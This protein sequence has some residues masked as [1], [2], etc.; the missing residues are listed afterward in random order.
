M[1]TCKKCGKTGKRW[2][3]DGLCKSC[4]RKTWICKECG[5]EYLSIN[6]RDQC[7]KCEQAKENIV[8]DICNKQFPTKKSLANHRRYHNESYTKM[9]GSKHKGKIVSEETRKK[10]SIARTGKKLSEEHKKSI[11]RAVKERW[12]SPG[13]KEQYH[14]RNA[15]K[16]HLSEE[17]KSLLSSIRTKAWQTDEYRQH[18]QEALDKLSVRSVFQLDSVKEKIK[19]TSEEKY[20]GMGFGSD[21]VRAKI[22]ATKRISKWHSIDYSEDAI[23]LL[24]DKD[25]FDNAV[26]NDKIDVNEIAERYNINPNHLI[27][28]IWRFGK[29]DNIEWDRR[30]SQAE[31]LWLRRFEKAGFDFIEQASIYDKKILKCDFLNEKRKF[32][33]EINPTYTHSTFGR[34]NYG[35]VEYDYHYNRSREAEKNGYEVFHVWDWEDRNLV[36]SFIKSKLH[37]D[38]HKVS[39]R[40]CDIVELSSKQANDFLAKNH[41]QGGIAKGQSA[42][43]G[44]VY[45]DVLLQVSTYGYS[46][47][48]KSYEWECLRSCSLLDWHIY[49]GLSRLQNYFI[50]QKKPKSLIAYTDYSRSNGAMNENINRRF[51]NYTGPSLVWYDYDRMLR[52]TLIR[53]KGAC[54]ILGIDRIDREKTGLSNN[55]IMLANGYYGV[56]DCGSKVYE[57][58]L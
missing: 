10:Q 47:F 24:E 25:F 31:R 30:R 8:C 44:L 1:Y 29:Q 46:R 27:Q 37:L 20:G 48:N 12:D 26:G 55:D 6:E 15:G 19:K 18:Q 23:R 57:L 41:L 43:Y 4:Q 14:E 9:M 39:A 42:C 38:S 13:Y 51:L 50:E 53:S 58:N 21:E 16:R 17:Q 35:N 52:D 32:A 22:D 11:S 40:K 2:M 3:R 28:A 49:G 36:L 56:Y 54:A 7:L 34:C 45:D 33:V 5:E